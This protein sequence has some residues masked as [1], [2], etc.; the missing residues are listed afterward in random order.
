M[1]RATPQAQRSPYRAR[2]ARPAIELT[3][4][5]RHAL[6]LLE[7]SRQHVFLTGR[8]GTGK[9]TLLQYFRAT[10]R[11]RIVVLAPTGVAAVQVQGQTIHSFCGFGPDITPQKARRQARGRQRLYQRLETMVI[12]EVSMV[13]ADLLDCVDQFLRVNGPHTDA[14][15]GGIQMLFIGDLYQLPPVVPAEEEALFTTHYP[16]PYFFAAHVMRT[17]PYTVVQLHKVY[18]QQDAAFVALLEALRTGTMD[19]PQLAAINTRYRAERVEPDRHPAIYLVTTNALAEQINTQHLTR[20]PGKPSTFPGTITGTFN[21]AQLPTDAR[22]TLKAGAR[23]M[24]LNNDPGG[25]WVNGTLGQVTALEQ[26]EDAVTIRVQLENGYRG[27]VAT[28]TWEAIRFVFDERT[29][30]IESEV[31]GSFTQYPLRLAWATTIHKAQGKTF[32][33]AI[34]DFGRGTFAPGQAY[35]ALSRCRSLEGLVL[36]T[37]LAPEHILVDARVQA[38]FATLPAP[39]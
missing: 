13:R 22:L 3:S 32:D 19:V 5:A 6:G 34:I 24:M 23:I 15:F 28:H 12:D 25:Q 14:P 31:V 9:S 7:D 26:R 10:T 39:S 36:R 20:L 38:F 11:K 27:I 2:L 30:R 29:Q 16:S 18:R 17:L 33:R 1:A 35:V 37:P 8:A 21:R 4:E